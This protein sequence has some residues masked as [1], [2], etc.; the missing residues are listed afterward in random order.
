MSFKERAFKVIKKIPYGRVTT[1]G[2]IATLA[3]LPRGARLVGGLLHF[4]SEQES[5][6]WQR[7][8]NRHGFISTKCLEHPKSLQ[9]ALLESEGI[10][11]GPDFV[12]DLK[13]YGWWGE[14]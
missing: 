2:T 10:E 14:A 11:V 8:I 3:G 5:L 4:T 1:Y 9:K 6:P 13:R 7:I 12:V